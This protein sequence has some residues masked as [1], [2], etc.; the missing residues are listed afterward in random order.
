[1]GY[2]VQEYL[3]K[4]IGIATVANDEKPGK[5]LK[6]FQ[7]IM[8]DKAQASPYELTILL[9]L[10]YDLLKYDKKAEIPSYFIQQEIMV[11]EFF[12][13]NFQRF[14]YYEFKPLIAKI[15]G[16]S[17]DLDQKERA[18]EKG[19]ENIEKVNN[20]PA[21][22]ILDN[23]HVSNEFLRTKSQVTDFQREAAAL[24]LLGDKLRQKFQEKHLQLLRQLEQERLAPL[25]L[26]Y[27]SQKVAELEG[28]F[29]GQAEARISEIFQG[30]DISIRSGEQFLLAMY[31][32]MS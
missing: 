5:T 31:K 4:K 29:Q 30:L 18:Q 3:M 12:R 11:Y 17:D 7:E 8:V 25:Q 32:K 27:N 22:Y 14:N 21:E 28:Y 15:K 1:M 16:D 26:Q 9:N 19:A 13:V 24:D 10:L 6:Y 2:S 20:T 23:N